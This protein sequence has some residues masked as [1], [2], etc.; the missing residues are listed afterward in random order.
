MKRMDEF[1]RF[2][3]YRK[4]MDMSDIISHIVAAV[5]HTD[6]KFKNTDEAEMIK[7]SLDCMVENAL[8][9]PAKIAGAL[10][11]AMDY[12]I[13]MENAT[14]I[15][16]AARELLMDAQ[17]VQVHGF[18]DVEYLDILRNEIEEFRELFAEWVKTFN[19]DNYSID[20]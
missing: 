12:D 13:K 19:H 10:E 9:I 18:K 7:F 4:A 16:K 1:D 8:I 3:I 11:E 5:E 6:I 15:R 2:P 14:L 17:N 20:R